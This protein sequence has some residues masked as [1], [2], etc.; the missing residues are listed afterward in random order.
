M[1]VVLAPGR[2]LRGTVVDKHG[3]AVPEAFV[4]AY[5]GDTQ[6]RALHAAE[7]GTQLEALVH[8]GCVNVWSWPKTC[9]LT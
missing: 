8:V 2:N 5:A 7:D 6:I 1:R 9:I 4:H 3:R